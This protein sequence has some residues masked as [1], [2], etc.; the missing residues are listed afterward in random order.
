[1]GNKNYIKNKFLYVF[2][3]FSL[4]INI[5]LLIGYGKRFFSNIKAETNKK[6]EIDIINKLDFHDGKGFQIFGKYHNEQNF[7]RLPSKFKKIVRPAVW[8]LSSCSSGINIRFSTNSPA[9]GAKW[10]VLNNSIPANMT[11]I[12]AC[13]IDL[14]CLVYGKW[15]YINSGIPIGINNERMLIYG[16]DTTHKEFLINL[17]LYDGV[18]NIEIG[19]IK[20]FSILNSRRKNKSNKPIV[21]YGTSITQGGSASRPGM[22]YPSIIGR[23][24]DIET[25]NLGFSG[26]GLFEQTV[27]Q[28]LCEIDASLFVIDCTPNSPPNIIRN[29]ALKLIQQ[30]RKCRPK[31]PI[32]LME[33]IN[34]EYSYFIQSDTTLYVS[35][36]YIRAQNN[37]LENVYKEA[38]NIGISDLYYLKTE[39]LIGFDHEG[40][41]D[42][43]HLSD[44][45]LY[46]I[47]NIV[48]A[49]INEILKNEHI[50]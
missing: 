44:L 32:L 29:N 28:A 14:Y 15:Q 27:G 6:G 43:T 2:L 16:L 48:Q 25:V 41:V 24:L 11:K 33:S 7:N 21:F 20:G 36:E 18:E 19:T 3:I 46:R 13:G 35:S 49:K 30:I 31:S 4:F 37:E 12:G 10:K 22:A 42:G 17:P 34:R 38:I 8:S 9:I 45:G 50:N 39:N 5:L 23:N 40:T 1:M 26:N 47:A